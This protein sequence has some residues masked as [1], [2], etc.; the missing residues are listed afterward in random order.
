MFGVNREKSRNYQ[1]PAEIFQINNQSTCGNFYGI[2]L[3]FFS[4][5]F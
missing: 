2:N 4:L 3:I 5:F 1:L